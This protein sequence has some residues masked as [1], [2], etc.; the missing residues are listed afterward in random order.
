MTRQ[1]AE[2]AIEKYG[3]QTK[4]ARAM[5]VSRKTLRKAIATGKAATRAST[6]TVRHVPAAGKSLADFRQAYDKSYI[7]PNKIKAALKELGNGWEYESVFAKSAGVSLM[8]MGAVRD[9]FAPFIV[10]IGRE[11]KRAWAGTKATADAMRKML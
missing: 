11:S 7:V 6:A 5:G 8:D 3:S 9:Q 10:V 1:E 4:A 2:T